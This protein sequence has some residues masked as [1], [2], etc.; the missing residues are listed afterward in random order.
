VIVGTARGDAT[1]ERIL[2]AALAVFLGEG[3]AEARLEEIRLRAG[4]STG[5]MYHHFDGKAAVAAALYAQ[6]LTGYQRAALEELRTHREPEAGVKA[7]VRHHLAWIAAHQDEARYLLMHQEADVAAAT[8]DA[9]R[10]ANREFF[11]EIRRLLLPL[12]SARARRELP[13]DVLVSL[14][15]GPAHE[16]G[17]NW[18]AG[19]VTTAPERAGRLLADAAWE[20]LSPYLD[21]ELSSL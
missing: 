5:S 11:G 8:D 1:R 21:R 20:S 18:L 3:I 7:A 15:V 16:Y 13:L 10:Q 19:R 12:L 14:L 4:V 6:C 17:R 2:R 9:I